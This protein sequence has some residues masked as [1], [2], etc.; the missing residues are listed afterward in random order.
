MEFRTQVKS[1]KVKFTFAHTDKTLL[2][3]SC[4]AENIGE[5]FTDHFFSVDIN[6]FGT[7]YN[8]FSIAKGIDL[9]IREDLF[10]ES[11]LFCHEDSYHSFMHHSRFSAPTADE[12]IRQI[13]ERLLTSSYNLKT[14]DRL[15]VTFGTAWVYRLKEDDRIVANCHKLPEKMFNRTRLTVDEIKEEWSRL[16]HLLLEINPKLK[17]LF[18]V[19]PVRHWKDGANGNQ[20]SK[21]TLL[22]AV[23]ELC[24]EF[25]ENVDYFPA[26][27]IMMDELRDY[28]FYAD[29][30]LH[31]SPLAVEYIWKCF[32]E[33]Y[34]SGESFMLL[35]DIAEI[36]KALNHRPFNPESET[37][38][39]FIQQTLR[40]AESINEQLGT[41]QLQAVITEL[42]EKLH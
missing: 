14:A 11:D 26:Y 6:P 3:G 37:Y 31:P 8:P 28:R 1:E 4:F 21:A 35:K 12:C 22:L 9:L 29:D 30:M 27:E 41:D 18:T 33:Q 34:L 38:S 10:S 36:R 7:L 15:I 40:K 2:L 20:L 19:S 16:L 5:K 42:K 23:D 32:S 13:N 24:R 25:P 17:V 39:R